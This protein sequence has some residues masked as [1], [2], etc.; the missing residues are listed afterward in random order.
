[1]DTITIDSHKISYTKGNFDE[2]NRSLARL[3][4]TTC[5]TLSYLDFTD[6]EM[7][8]TIKT[9]NVILCEYDQKINQPPLSMCLETPD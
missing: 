8:S 4:Q 9:I 3:R 7:L 1:M 6:P 2:R 5:D